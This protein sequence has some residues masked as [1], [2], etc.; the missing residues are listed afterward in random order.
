MESKQSD[1][2]TFE[3]EEREKIKV[4]E[5]KNSLPEK[6]RKQTSTQSVLEGF[7]VAPTQ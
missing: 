5:Y 1:E 6:G 7:F 4:E 2:I 3:M